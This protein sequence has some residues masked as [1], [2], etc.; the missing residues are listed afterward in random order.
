MF[1]NL[2]KNNPTEIN[3]CIGN[4]IIAK[5]NQAK[6]LGIT[7]D[8]NQ[9]WSNQNTGKGGVILTIIIKVLLRKI[10]EI[11]YYYFCYY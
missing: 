9:G 1:L 8:E 2:K 11:Y 3:L 4:E 10:F 7:M 6:L 5:S